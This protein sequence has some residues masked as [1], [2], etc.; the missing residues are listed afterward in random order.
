MFDY[1][2]NLWDF[3]R[4]CSLVEQV[5]EDVWRN[6]KIEIK[7]KKEV[8]IEKFSEAL[9]SEYSKVSF[10]YSLKLLKILKENIE[11]VNEFS[12]QKLTKV[13]NRKKYYPE[14]SYDL[15]NTLHKKFLSSQKFLLDVI[16]STPQIVKNSIVLKLT[17]APN[18]P[19]IT[20]DDEEFYPIDNPICKEKVFKIPMMRASSW[21]GALRYAAMRYVL[22]GDSKEKIERRKI[23]L[24][25]FGTEKDSIENYLDGKFKEDNILERWKKEVEELKKKLKVKELHL[26]GRLIFFPT[27][28]NQIDLDVIAPHDRKTK[29]IT[30]R[31]PILF[32]VVPEGRNG[33][34]PLLYYPF[35]LIE[36]LN[37]GNEDE[38]RNALNEIK[39]D[40]EFLA[41]IIPEMLE[42]HGFGAKTSSG[43]GIAKIE[44][45]NEKRIFLFNNKK[46]EI[47][48]NEE[49]NRKRIFEVVENEYE[50]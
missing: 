5:W 17:F 12:K 27:F 14:I 29:T 10:L 31:G 18:K 49:E 25:L 44:K 50:K 46:I 20:K 48:N 1:Y 21:K 26:R 28:F 3:D 30:E 22:Q 41:T 45:E 7:R 13:V 4:I 6:R 36:K 43:Y 39:K 15:I 19:L 37:S 33:I 34:F 35:G 24:R 40:F 23:M 11:N 42:T 38:K 2:R 32:E 8:F 16:N 9:F 47:G